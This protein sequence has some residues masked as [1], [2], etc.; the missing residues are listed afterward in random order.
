VTG[1]E[2][3]RVKADA[4][5]ETHLDL[6]ID[7]GGID[8]TSRVDLNFLEVD[9]AGTDGE[10]HLVSIALR[11]LAVG[12]REREELRAVLREET[13][14]LEVGSVASTSERREIQEVS[15]R[16]GGKEGSEGGTNPV[17]RMT[18]P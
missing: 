9:S 14:G 10:S 15:A 13:V 11:V 17:E 2:V 18:G 6:G 8:E 3:T 5:E 12:R 4:K 1:N 7:V 16:K